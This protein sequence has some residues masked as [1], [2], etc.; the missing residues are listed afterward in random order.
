M[1]TATT[2]AIDQLHPVIS[3]ARSTFS[4]KQRR[5]RLPWPVGEP[6]RILSID[7]GGIKGIF[8]A[9]LLAGL[10]RRFLGG[11]SISHHFDLITGTSTGGILALGLAAGKTS[12]ELLDVYQQ[13]GQQIFPPGR[14]RRLWR[15]L[16]GVSLHRYDRGA[17][18]SALDGALGVRTL[19]E[20]HSRLCIPAFEGHHGEVYIFKTPHHPDYRMDGRERMVTVGQATSAAPC[21][22]RAL[23]SDGYRVV[24]GGIWA[25]NPVMIGL[26]DALSCF[27]IDPAQIQ[28]LSL[29]CGRE[30]VR[31][32]HSK[33]VGGLWSWRNVI[34]AAMDLQSQNALGQAR[35]LIGPERVTRLE[36]ELTRPIELDDWRRSSVELPPEA[37]RLLQSAAENIARTFL[38]NEV[39]RPNLFWPPA[40]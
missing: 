19:A 35:L 26:V 17:L 32:S 30:P 37:D 16:R 11:R 24:D 10:E 39:R 18:T 2:S 40:E 12:Q 5:E 27:A 22:F 38:T 31:V 7:G 28:I 34:F 1:Q 14:I 36:P 9:A 20:S 6:F 21:Y 23:D 4:T 25:N 13:R 29:G 3:P 33:A 15:N 8:P